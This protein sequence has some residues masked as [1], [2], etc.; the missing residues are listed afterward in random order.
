MKLNFK[1]ALVFILSSMITLSAFS[2]IVQPAKW[3]VEFSKKDVKV[4]ETLEVLIKGDIQDTWHVFSNDFDPEL[5]PILATFN[6]EKNDSYE[7]VGKVT[8]IKPH[9]HYDEVWEGEVSYFEKKAEFRQTIKVLQAD[10]KVA[11]SFDYQACT[12]VSGQCVTGEEDFDIALTAEGG[13]VVKKEAKAE[14]STPAEKKESKKGLWAIFIGA[15]LGGLIAIVTPCVFP[16]IPMTVSYFMHSGGGNKAKGRMNA[17][18]YGFSIIA[19][20]TVVGTILA[21]VMGPDFA[22]FLST[23]WVPNILFFIIFVVFAFSF[24][25]M[26]EMT[27]PSWMVN[28]SVANED[29]GGFMGSFF[30]AFTL[31]LV[32]FSC[33][34]PIVGT[35]LVASAGGEVLMPIIGMLGFSLAFALPFT[36]FA[37]FPGWLNN[38]PKSGGWLNSVKVVL[39]FLELALGLKFLSVADQTYHWGILDREVYLA[40]WIVI[41]TLLGFYLLGKLMFSHDSPLKSISVPRLMLAIASFSFVVY[42]IPGMFGAPLKMLSGFTPPKS[43]LDFDLPTMIVENAGSGGVKH[44][45]I[46]GKYSDFLHL[47]PGF[48]GYF[49]MDEAIAASKAQN[50][51]VFVDFTGHGCVNCR[52]MESNVWSHPEVAKRLK[53]EYIIVA[54]YVDDKTKLPKEEWIVSNYDGKKKKTLGK[55]NAN[56]QIE[57]YNVNAQPYYVLLDKEGKDLVQPTAYDLNVD[58]FIKFLDEGIKNF[59]NGKSVAL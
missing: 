14:E 12:D 37:I 13:S 46:S 2:Q 44:E 26:F 19:I 52:E 4:G 25:G 7:L 15:F 1:F 11:G 51:P 8:P 30:M 23:H 39:G 5:G 33:T 27:M 20:Y 3:K 41:F 35:I 21:V 56:Y 47:P 48:Q 45:K 50:K 18:F 10:V 43:G 58:N 49:D 42:M 54:M 28:K 57:R 36:L 24:F 6:F 29:K 59:K 31:V 55:I 9:K 32:S 17:F 34:G 40:I 16:M 22:N 38:M 53:N